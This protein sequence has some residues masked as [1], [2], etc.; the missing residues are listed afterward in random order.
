MGSM[1]EKRVAYEVALYGKQQIAEGTYA[2]TFEKPEGF[3]FKAGQHVR[4]TLIDPT[5]TDA[6][7]N[8]R[9]LTMASTPQEPDLVFAIRMRD[10]AFK[11]VLSRMRP[12]EKVLIEMLLES[13]HGSFVLH[14]DASKPAVFIVGG[15]GI[16]PA[17]SM[18][19]DAIQRNLPH[20]KF[21]FYSNRRPEDAPFLV[22]LQN[23]AEQNN[24]FELIA[25]ITEPE[26]SAQSWQ[27]ETGFIDR[28][29]LEKYVDDLESPI[30]YVAG[31]PDMVG[32]MQTVLAEV[33]VSNENIRAEE[34]AGFE[35][36]HNEEVSNSGKNHPLVDDTGVRPTADRPPSTPRWVKVTGI[37]VGVVLLLFVILLFTRGPGG[38][39]PGMHGSGDGDTLLAS[40]TEDSGQQ[41]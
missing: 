4:M 8:S 20:K 14:E 41:P 21:L 24:S 10:T 22:E 5:E 33:G 18:I 11:R 34:F 16:V 38:H 31:L 39:G 32:A 36:S 17:Y 28:A 15:I 27:G 1:S 37:I 12:G 6:E 7:D 29:M 3:H 26:K 2:F 40:V 19:K 25:T 30:F 13:P 23:L 9:F 35:L